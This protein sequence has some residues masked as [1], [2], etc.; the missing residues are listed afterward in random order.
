MTG[1]QIHKLR[2]DLDLSPFAL[3][4]VLGVHV[5]TIYRWET[6][7]GRTRL[8]PLPAQILDALFACVAARPK[9]ATAL[10]KAIVDGLVTGGTLTALYGTLKILLATSS[11]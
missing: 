8:D 11:R 7:P 10:K 3:A 5:S 9:A 2:E 1:R 4:G 6:S